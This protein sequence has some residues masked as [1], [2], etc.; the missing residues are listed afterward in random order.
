MELRLDPA[1][2]RAATRT[3][4]TAPSDRGP[5]WVRFAPRELD[6]HAV[7]RLEAWFAFARRRASESA[8]SS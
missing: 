6:D 3:P 5:E 4:D 1:I 2:A 8:R 7:D